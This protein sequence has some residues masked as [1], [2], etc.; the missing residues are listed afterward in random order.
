MACASVNQQ[1]WCMHGL[2]AN[3]GVVKTR[4]MRCLV[5]S[6]PMGCVG[7]HLMVFCDR[8]TRHL[9]EDQEISIFDLFVLCLSCG[10]FVPSESLG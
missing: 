8:L 2:D 9:S 5:R 10:L 7:C 3:P 1:S 4:S 6:W